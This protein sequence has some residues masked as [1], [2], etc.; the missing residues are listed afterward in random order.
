MSYINIASVV[1][2]FQQ[3]DQTEI[4]VL[5]VQDLDS[6]LWRFPHGRVKLGKSLKVTVESYVY[7]ITSEQVIFRKKLSTNRNA[8]ASE[9]T[10]YSLCKLLRHTSKDKKEHIWLPYFPARNKLS[11]IEEQEVID[12]A[13]LAIL[14]QKGNS[15]P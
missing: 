15:S 2:R 12:L 9:D 3:S 13:F 14:E 1:Y 5:L 11:I 4:Q 7:Q 6:K 10:V 8:D